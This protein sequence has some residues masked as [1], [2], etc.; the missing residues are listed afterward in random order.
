MAS[1][2]DKPTAKDA[3]DSIAA[4]RVSLDSA[5]KASVL[6]IQWPRVGPPRVLARGGRRQLRSPSLWPGSAPDAARR[7]RRAEGSGEVSSCCP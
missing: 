6:G 3:W 2:K 4:T 7:H 5:R 1:L